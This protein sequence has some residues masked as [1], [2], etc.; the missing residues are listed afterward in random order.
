VRAELLQAGVRDVLAYR[1]GGELFQGRQH[2]PLIRDLLA[3]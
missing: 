3:G 2:L 1:V